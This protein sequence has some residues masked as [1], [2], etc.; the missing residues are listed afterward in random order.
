MVEHKGGEIGSERGEGW[1]GD[2]GLACVCV[3]VWVYEGGWGSRSRISM[4]QLQLK[5]GMWS[6]GKVWKGRMGYKYS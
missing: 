4:L 2:G 3:C 6:G 1:R 5:G